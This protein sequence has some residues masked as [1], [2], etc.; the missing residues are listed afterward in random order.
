M[1]FNDMYMYEAI[2]RPKENA[3]MS[4]LRFIREVGYD[5]FTEK[6]IIDR[7][8]LK[9]SSTPG[10]WRIYRSVNKRDERKAKLEL[11]E[12]LIKQLV[13]PESVS[14]KDP[15]S[16]WKD[17]L[18]QPHNKAERLFLIDLD[19]NDEALAK[20][21]IY[22]PAITVHDKIKSPNG[23]HLICDP[24]DPRQIEGMPEAS[25]VKDA[26]V[27]IKTVTVSK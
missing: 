2:K 7:L 9:I 6:E 1:G 21:I 14:N 24:F 11:A 19:S 20:K 26:L 10:I 25:V 3:D 4:G 23:F 22:N 18:M 15:E 8:E 13:Y 5:R 17:I 27:Y 16:L 12:T